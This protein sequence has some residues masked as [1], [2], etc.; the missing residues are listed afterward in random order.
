MKWFRSG[1][2]VCPPYYCFNHGKDLL[3][4]KR[5][6]QT[7]ISTRIE[8]IGL[9]LAAWELVNGQDIWWR[10]VKVVHNLF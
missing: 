1:K 3:Y 10:I 8:Y 6:F 7:D 9:G 2:S 5:L 4:I